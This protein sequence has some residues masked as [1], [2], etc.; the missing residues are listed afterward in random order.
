MASSPLQ[1]TF[2]ATSRLTIKEQT[3]DEMYGIPE[4]S[5][6]IEVR[7]PQTHGFGRKMYTD[8]EIVCKTNIPAFK[9]KYSKV[10]RR[11]SDFEW[12]R[13]VLERESSRVNIPPLPGKVFTNRF[14]D[15]VIEARREGLERFLQM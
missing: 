2:D 7:N 4:N 8:Y 5:L 13:D 9:L 6:E 1:K 10:R 12:F 11:Y 14:S 3:P 15:E